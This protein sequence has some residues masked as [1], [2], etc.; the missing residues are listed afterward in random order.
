MGCCAQAT[1]SGMKYPHVNL[2]DLGLLSKDA[3]LKDIP[4]EQLKTSQGVAIVLSYVGDSDKVKALMWRLNRKTKEYFIKAN[5]LEGSLVKGAFQILKEA[6][7]SG[8]LQMVTRYQHAEYRTVMGA[9]KKIGDS[10]KRI[11]FLSQEY[12]GLYL[13]VMKER[14]M[15]KEVN[16]YMEKCKLLKD[17]YEKYSFFVHGYFLPYLQ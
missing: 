3:P 12:P 10:E 14:G 11:E 8:D 2:S 6:E 5:H 15:H 13:Y 16:D 7:A 9:L 1:E 17:S 4:F